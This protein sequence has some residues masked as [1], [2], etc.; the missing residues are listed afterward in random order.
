M[1][2][3]EILST[4][5]RSSKGIKQLDQQP[6]LSDGKEELS[7]CGHSVLYKCYSDSDECMLC[8]LELLEADINS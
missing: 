5:N 2:L 3:C 4:T 6:T 7:E 8:D 1:Y